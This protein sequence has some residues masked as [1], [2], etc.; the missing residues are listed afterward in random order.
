M[1]WLESNGPPVSPPAR[2]GFGSVLIE[3]IVATYFDGSAELN[4]DP[5]GVAFHLSGTIAKPDAT[6]ATDP[7]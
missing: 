1:H 4:F 3:K 6:P 5:A 7:Y 2:S